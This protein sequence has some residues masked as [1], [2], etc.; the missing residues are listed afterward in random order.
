MSSRPS[1]ADR[2]PPHLGIFYHFE[3]LY[4]H[5]DTKRTIR[6]VAQFK[7][8]A[9]RGK[10]LYA[11]TLE[12]QSGETVDG[13]MR[14][15]ELVV[16]VGPYRYTMVDSRS[17]FRRSGSQYAALR[18]DRA[19][20]PEWHT[21]RPSRGNVRLTDLVPYDPVSKDNVVRT[22]TVAEAQTYIDKQLA[23]F[24]LANR[25]WSA[26][27]AAQ[28]DSPT[29]IEQGA[30]NACSLVG[31]L[32]LVWLVRSDESAKR[33]W[34]QKWQKLSPANDPFADVGSMLDAYDA[35]IGLPKGVVYVPFRTSDARENVW[36]KALPGFVG[37]DF[38]TPHERIRSFFERHLASGRPIC[39]NQ[40]EHT[41]VAIAY[42]DSGVLCVDSFGRRHYERLN[43]Y[44]EWCGGLSVIQSD[45]LYQWVRDAAMLEA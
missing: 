23:A 45:Y 8:F 13:M 15:P 10:D 9:F 43:P 37:V 25:Y 28:K 44:V 26:Q 24:P 18:T 36:N 41:R 2:F 38:A 4:I 3:A 12:T 33:T 42:N 1:N 40:G 29:F 16:W 20:D 22:I 35:S 30:Q 27:L 21:W 7:D 31:F 34:L 5:G 32:H 11:C 6:M 14:S 17:S 19:K 39:F